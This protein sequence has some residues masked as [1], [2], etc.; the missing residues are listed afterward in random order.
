MPKALQLQYEYYATFLTFLLSC[1]QHNG[2]SWK[3]NKRRTVKQNR[4]FI[5]QRIAKKYTTCLTLWPFY[6]QRCLNFISLCFFKRHLILSYTHYTTIAVT[7]IL[8]LIVNNL[9]IIL[10]IRGITLS[11]ELEDFLSRKC[12]LQ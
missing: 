10:E 11:F 1:T 7:W 6:N 2:N 5:R 8:N 9:R 4:L 3:L 12:S